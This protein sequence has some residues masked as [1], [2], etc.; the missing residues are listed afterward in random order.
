M[1][2]ISLALFL[3]KSDFSLEPSDLSRN[4]EMIDQ[5]DV[6]YRVSGGFGSDTAE[7]SPLEEWE[8]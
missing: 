1:P 8:E 3:L 5:P 4:A 2:Q 7:S 6:E